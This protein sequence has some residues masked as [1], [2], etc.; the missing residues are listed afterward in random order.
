MIPILYEA[1][2]SAFTSN[3][4]G[5]LSDAISCKVTE[6]RN[7]VYEL[8][9]TYPIDG[10]HYD[11]ISENRIILAQPHDGGLTEPFQIY[12]ITKPLNG[13]VTINAEHISYR[14]NSMVCMPFTSGT[15][16]EALVDIKNNSVET[17][18]FN[19]TTDIESTV[20]FTL[21]TPSNIRGLLCGQSGSILDV[22]GGG[23][24]EFRRWDV[25][26][27]RARGADNGVTLRYGKNITD[28]KHI[29][30][31]SN[32][33]TGIVP[34]WSDGSQTVTLPEGVVLSTHASEYPFHI[35]KTVDFSAEY[36]EKPTVAQLRAK[37]QSYVTRNEGWKLRKNI[38]IS[39]VALWNTEEYKDIAPLERVQ[40]C[41]T[42]H[43]VYGP[44]GLN[45]S[46]RVVKTDY[47]VL[48]ERYNSITLGDT[49]YT[50]DSVFNA[51]ITKVEESQTSHMQK[52]IARATKL[53]EGGLG[54][55]VVMN[56]NADGEP[57]EIL[58]MDTDDIQT[59]VNVIRMNMNGI[60]FSTHGYNGPFE[61]AWTIDGHFVAD[62]IDTGT[63]TADIV[64]TGVLSDENG[65]TTFNLETGAL[66]SK[67]LTIDSQYF[68]LSNTG[69]I[70]SITEDGRKLVMERGKIT[71]YKT[72]GTESAALEIGDGYF[73]IIGKLA[74][75][76]VVGVSGATSFV[77]DVGY[78]LDTLGNVVT[79]L[80][81]S[82][83]NF[84]TDVSL[85]S[86]AE[87][88][89]ATVTV[90]GYVGTTYAS[91]S[92]TVYYQDT[93]YSLNKTDKYR[94]GL[95]SASQRQINYN[96]ATI[97][98]TGAINSSYGIIQSIS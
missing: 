21:N 89:S 98:D 60:G 8:E 15:L 26:L 22:Y 69:K 82:Y 54:G 48:Q 63:L 17:N 77:K 55:H 41:D 74:L 88:K 56:V 57:Q 75:N 65:N 92:G 67:N 53:I 44:Y 94:Y 68:K 87:S 18:P 6:E 31:M 3:G 24:Y 38:T 14:L 49:Y 35:I 13:I 29:A 86:T 47:D 95:L 58:I 70:T 1:T 16:R 90:S 4:L 66:V 23:D 37:A 30:D 43:V 40:M 32:V 85:N 5:R 76:G 62:F 25:I 72:D 33:Y 73:N 71:G 59:A 97:A 28:F 36:Q 7:G 52:A 27:H 78:S 10:A 81:M 19:F 61:T 45:F 39:F 80:N 79:S 20:D 83:E 84:V 11:D 34:Y 51:E 2:E 96:K 91:L 64:K 50:L 12:K 46:T 9:M 93:T 42:V